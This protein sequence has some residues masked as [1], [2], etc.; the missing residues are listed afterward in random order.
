MYTCHHQHKNRYCRR[1]TFHEYLVSATTFISN[2][3]L[4]NSVLVRLTLYVNGT[5]KYQ[6]TGTSL[7][8]TFFLSALCSLPPRVWASGEWPKLARY[9]SRKE[10]ENDIY[11]IK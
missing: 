3:T 4:H 8:V 10:V 9:T 2:S 1:K 11:Q 6:H 5:E 7:Y